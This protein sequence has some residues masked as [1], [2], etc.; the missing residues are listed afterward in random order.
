[1]HNCVVIKELIANAKQ[2][3]LT[4]PPNDLLANAI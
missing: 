4:A 3:K 1:M 2:Q